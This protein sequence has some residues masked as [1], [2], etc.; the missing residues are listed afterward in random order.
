[1]AAV[2]RPC[3]GPNHDR[4]TLWP[5]VCAET[6]LAR[7]QKIFKEASYCPNTTAF[8]DRGSSVR[9]ATSATTVAAE[10]KPLQQFRRAKTMVKV[11]LLPLAPLAEE[12]RHYSNDRRS[13]T[14]TTA[15]HDRGDHFAVQSGRAIANAVPNYYVSIFEWFQILTSLTGCERIQSVDRNSIP[16]NLTRLYF[17]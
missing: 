6:E 12:A 15:H 1:L 8:G 16:L 14:E 4:T 10:R 13:S 2:S 3:L 7:Q 11:I 5:F 17:C 9:G